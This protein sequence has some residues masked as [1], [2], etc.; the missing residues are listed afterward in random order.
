ME[1]FHNTLLEMYLAYRSKVENLTL[2]EGLSIVTTL[3]ND[4]KHS[5]TNLKS[6]EIIFRMSSS[7]FSP[8]EITEIVTD[9]RYKTDGQVCHRRT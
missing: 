6:R 9:R 8:A 5:A 7:L 1:R 4:T 2:Y 3:Y